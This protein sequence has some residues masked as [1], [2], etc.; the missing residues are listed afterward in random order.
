MAWDHVLSG[1]LSVEEEYAVGNLF[2]N[3][4][5]L[6]TQG[7][8]VMHKTTLG[9]L[10]KDL[11]VELSCST[12]EI[13]S[14]DSNGRTSL[15]WAAKRGDTKAVEVLLEHG[16]DVSISDAQ[17]YV[18]I[19]YARNV[20][21]CKALLS[22]GASPI[23]QNIWGR[24]PIHSACEWG[25]DDGVIHVLVTAGAD[26][27]AADSTGETALHSAIVQ[28]SL[29]HAAR[30]LALGADSNLSNLSGDS[31]LRFA[32]MFNTHEILDRMLQY[33]C[34]F[35]EVRHIFGHRFI[36][37]IARTADLRTLQILANVKSLHMDAT[38][39]D[40]SGKTAIEYLEERDGC[41][42]LRNA[43]YQLFD[44]KDNSSDVLKA[45][46]LDSATELPSRIPPQEKISELRK[47]EVSTVVLEVGGEDDEPG[48]DVE[49]DGDA[50]T[51]FDA[52]ET[53]ESMTI[54]VAGLSAA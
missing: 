7:F 28:R 6:E 51:F 44:G 52:M 18:P 21:C 19:H 34:S 16:A 15:A 26:V 43:F 27:N 46:V 33:P 49:A 30:L 35:E 9:L 54:G 17:G 14:K 11:S 3:T 53:L 39:E 4:D 50:V 2:G 25:S 5:C 12:S 23:S 47:S 36:H 22:G 10:R 38:V 13:N 48:Q 41:Q 8:S 45:A 40:Q 31:S 1:K 24:S 42:A 29:K 20:S 32:I 37:S